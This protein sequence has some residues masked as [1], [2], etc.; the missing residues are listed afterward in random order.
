MKCEKCKNEIDHIFTSEFNIY[1]QDDDYRF[2]LIQDHE[3]ACYFETDKNWTGYEL[4]ED[5]MTERIECPH[6]KQ[7]PFIDKEI[8]TYDIVRVVMF[9]DKEKQD[10]L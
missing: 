8:Q 10:G 4:T 1:G 2:D 6:C 7:Y 3:G 9:L 5:E